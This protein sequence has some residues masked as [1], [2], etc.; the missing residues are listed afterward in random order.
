MPIP[1]GVRASILEKVEGNVKA[2]TKT[3]LIPELST[4]R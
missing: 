4:T 2:T 1:W 3:P